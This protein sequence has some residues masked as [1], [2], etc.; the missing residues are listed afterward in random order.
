MPDEE[1]R[2]LGLAGG[3]MARIAKVDRAVTEAEM[4]QMAAAIERYWNL[5]AENAL[6]VANVAVSSLDVNYDYYR[7]TR[8]FATMTTAEERQ[9]FLVALFRVA[10]ADGEISFD[11]TEEIRTISKGINVTHQDFINAKLAVQNS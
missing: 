8:E 4:S 9:R 2:R 10:A 11:E 6:F 1:L 3:L 5:S 7:M